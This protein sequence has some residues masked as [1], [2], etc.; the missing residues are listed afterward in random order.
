MTDRVRHDEKAGDE[1]DDSDSDKKDRKGIKNT[2]EEEKEKRD[3]GLKKRPKKYAY[4]PDPNLSF[5][6]GSKVSSLVYS[7]AIEAYFCGYKNTAYSCEDD[8]EISANEALS[9]LGFLPK[10]VDNLI[11]FADNGILR[12]Y[13]FTASVGTLE[14]PR[15]TEPDNFLIHPKEQVLGKDK[16]HTDHSFSVPSVKEEYSAQS[17]DSRFL[18]MPVV[19]NSKNLYTELEY[20]HNPYNLVDH[21]Y[22]N[23]KNAEIVTEES[24]STLSEISNL[25]DKDNVKNASNRKMVTKKK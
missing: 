18:C 13:F 8:G 19:A 1:D 24:Q 7:L 25:I 22:E 3:K 14:E 17:I 20:Q 9:E 23:E 21:S 11:S 10:G 6:I 15:S 16:S 4:A 5:P 2:L 12:R